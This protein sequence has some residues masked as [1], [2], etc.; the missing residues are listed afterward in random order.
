MERSERHGRERGYSLIELMIAV[1]VTLLVMAGVY[2]LML[3]NQEIYEAQTQLADVQQAARVALDLMTREIRMAGSDPSGRAFG[4]PDDDCLTSSYA[5]PAD[6]TNPEED[7]IAPLTVAEPTR[8]RVKLDRG[9]FVLGPESESA[10]P[11]PAPVPPAKEDKNSDGDYLDD[12]EDGLGDGFINDPEED[13]EYRWDSPAKKLVRTYYET[14]PDSSCM[15]GDSAGDPVSHPIATNVVEFELKYYDTNPPTAA[16][17][18]AGSYADVAA[19]EAARDA[20]DPPMAP[21]DDLSAVR[22]VRIRLSV[23][24]EKVDPRKRAAGGS[25][26]SKIT[27][28]SEAAIRNRSL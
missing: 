7:D 15:T 20:C 4:E 11:T 9:T 6:P 5:T 22:R 12:D 25:G 18:A 17:P 13:V 24:T 3:Q 2:G 23:E 16:C 28:V 19:Y 10:D 27:L 21:V 1:T 14:D 26:K 8:I